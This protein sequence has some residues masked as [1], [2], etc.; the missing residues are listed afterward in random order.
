MVLSEYVLAC[1]AWLLLWIRLLGSDGIL[2]RWEDEPCI[3]RF[4]WNK[5][6]RAGMVAVIMS[7]DV[8]R[9]PNTI[10][11]AKESNVKSDMGI[12]NLGD[13]KPTKRVGS[14]LLSSQSCT[15]NR[16]NSWD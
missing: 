14:G 11:T 7:T 5:G 4:F 16:A 9:L 1:D 15:T 13:G 10:R 2:L 6:L 12:S 8:S 3:A